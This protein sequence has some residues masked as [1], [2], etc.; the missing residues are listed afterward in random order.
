MK[1]LSAAVLSAL[2]AAPALAIDPDDESAESQWTAPA[3]PGP[4]AP[5]PGSAE[6]DYGTP[7]RRRID[8]S[9][10]KD[11]L[12]QLC[13]KL[14]LK[15]RVN[16]VSSPFGSA[17]AGVSR[18]ME[19]DFDNSLALIDEEMLAGH[20]G[21]SETKAFTDSTGLGVYAGAGLSGKSM[22]V[23]R[24]GTFNTCDEVDRLLNVTDVKVVFPASPRRIA[25]MAK[26]ELW[27]LP[28]TINVGYGASLSDA[29]AAGT[30]ISVGWSKTKNGAASMTLF[31]L[32]ENKV[33]F[34][35]RVDFVEIRSR[36]LGFSK[37]LDP[38][39][40]ASIGENALAGLVD[41]A[42]ARELRKVTSLYAGLSRSR[43][44]GRRLIL[45]YVVDPTDPAQAEAL[46]EAL[47]GNLRRLIQYAARVASSR[48]SPEETLQAL[49]TLEE[50]NSET[51]GRP[52]YAA[53]SDFGSKVRS[54]PINVPFFVNRN[55]SEAFGSDAV[56]RF[57][58]EEGRFEFHSADRTPNAEY[59]NTPFVGPL[60][61]DLETRHVDVIT[62]APRGQAPSEPIAVYIHNQ[63]FLRLSVSRVGQMVEDANGVLRLAGSARTG[64]PDPSMELPA[65]KFL[66]QP[67]PE[68]PGAD[69]RERTEPSDQKGWM[70]FTLVMNQK[71]VQ[72]ALSASTS[73]V[74]K[75]FA[76]SVPLADRTWAEWLAA[77]GK[78]EDGKLVY[79][80]RRAREELSIREDQDT[81][82]LT[83]LSR[84]AAGV[85]A[86]VASA[87]GE[88]SPEGRARGLAKAFS[89]ENASG[90]PPQD[91]LRVLVQ[92]MDP[93]DLTGHFAT[94]TNGSTHAAAK[95][96]ASYELKKGRAEV[97]MLRE[98]GET[99][100]RFAENGALND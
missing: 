9:R 34:R 31:R 51:L 8:E 27:R 54:F 64:R 78:L 12:D 68:E 33:R 57:T 22:V 3:P 85:A 96:Q 40:F 86:D 56:T 82:W 77:N 88:S 2:L 84:E 63:G 46:S 35:F 69:G 93:M 15:L 28:L 90:L 26:G 98:A 14:K 80:Q 95:L 60:V 49:E 99:R 43:S 4:G 5:A 23:R 52:A 20:I 19:A 25:E 48:T 59:F 13:R 100:G 58:G 44:D 74:L 39:E 11:V 73:E 55:L 91:V 16:L 87:A 79:D 36:S 10:R 92:F 81:G 67:R 1:N 47:R 76:A 7:D 32:A 41:R 65:A 75:A 72:A 97:A 30:V 70:S 83:K 50:E 17:S 6:G 89:M 61:K 38:V 62:D 45:E 42:I 29:L 94:A 21:L 53:R 24:L 66:P 18:R 37:T 71:A